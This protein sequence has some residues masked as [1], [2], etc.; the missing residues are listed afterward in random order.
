VPVSGKAEKAGRPEIR[1]FGG[2]PLLLWLPAAFS[3]ARLPKI[4]QMVFFSLIL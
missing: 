3:T 2:Y 1:I 4:R